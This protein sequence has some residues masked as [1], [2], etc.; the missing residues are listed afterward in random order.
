[1]TGKAALVT[2]AAS[3]LGRATALRLASVGA[4]IYAVD[5]SAAALEEALGE[6]RA[7]GVRAEGRA[8]DLGVR[9]NCVG[10]VAEA[11]AAFGRLDALCNVAA[12]LYTDHATDM[13]ASDWERTLAVNLSAP[14]YLIQA[15]IPHLL[16]VDG[17][18]V[19]VTSCAAHK[20]QA[21]S[22]AY[23]ATK[24][25]L[26]HMTKALAMEYMHKPIRFNAVAPGGMMTNIA[27]G[28]K[29]PADFDRSIF[30]RVAPLRGLV[31]VDEVAELTAFLA[32]P[33]AGGYHGACINIDKGITAD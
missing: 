9:E 30:G 16:E 20:A 21:Y 5:I 19:N 8:A 12:V 29:L 24:A 15:A 7:L 26:S 10:V 22:A 18:V 2:G 13:P 17:A 25:G 28:M 32:T 33:A 6:L 1:M 31:E 11:V 14:F 27:K 3:G 4:D 23:C